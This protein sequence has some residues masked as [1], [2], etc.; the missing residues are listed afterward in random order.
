M[1][2]PSKAVLPTSAHDV[3]ATVPLFVFIQVGGVQGLAQK[4]IFGFTAIAALT[5]GMDISGPR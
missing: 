4:R 5:Y 3:E 1:H 2:P